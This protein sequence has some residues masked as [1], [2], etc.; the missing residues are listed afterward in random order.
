MLL[1]LVQGPRW[2]QQGPKEGK[3]DSVWSF[4][5]PYLALG[6]F[7]LTGAWAP[8]S[9]GQLQRREPRDPSRIAAMEA[10]WLPRP[11]SWLAVFLD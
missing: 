8:M 4:E 1:V 5:S 6:C 3:G 7:P 9:E 11:C 10:Q 2:V